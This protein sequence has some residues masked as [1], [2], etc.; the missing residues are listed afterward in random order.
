MWLTKDI[1]KEYGACGVGLRWFYHQ[2]PQGTDIM[3]VIMHPEVDF[4]FLHWGFANLP[5]SDEE[6]KAYYQ[7]LKINVH[8]KDKFSIIE[9]SN[10]E[11]SLYVVKS[12]AVKDSS[13]I[14]ISENVEGSESVVEG[15]YVENSKQIFNS[16]FVYGS[17]KILNSANITN[18]EQIVKTSYAVNSKFVSGAENIINSQ[19]VLDWTKSTR[20]IK[21]SF[22]IIQSSGLSNC[23]FCCGLSDAENMLFNKP[24]DAAQ[25]EMIKKQFSQIFKYYEPILVSEEEWPERQIPLKTPSENPFVFAKARMTS[26]QY[27]WIKSLP[28]YNAELM[29]KITLD[30][31]FLEEIK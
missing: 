19:Y 6:K 31:K 30:E 7:T 18:C 29:Y 9:S 11:N 22:F 23:G 10:I 5:I 14:F 2:F 21:D 13:Y 12:K 24:L 26:N 28:N 15:V 4:H 1:L 25:I 17:S 3:N 27:K 8:D 16:N 20:N